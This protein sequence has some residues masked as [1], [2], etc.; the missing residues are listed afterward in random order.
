MGYPY[1]SDR[2]VLFASELVESG[3]EL[4]LALLG[5]AHSFQVVLHRLELHKQL[6][7]DCAHAE[8]SILKRQGFEPVFDKRDRMIMVHG[9]GLPEWGDATTFL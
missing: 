3:L 6:L 9:M 8:H 2:D 4:E 7:V 1:A 5:V